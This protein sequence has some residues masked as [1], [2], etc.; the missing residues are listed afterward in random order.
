MGALDQFLEGLL[1]DGRVAFAGPPDHPPAADDLQRAGDRLGR[2]YP[3]HALDVAGPPIPFD[4]GAAT[5]A[6]VWLHWACWFA[7]DRSA[8][9]EL[10]GQ[11][12]GLPPAPG[13]A[14]EHLSAD[15]V[16]RFLP[17]V[18]RRAGSNTWDPLV[19]A[20]DAAGRHWPLSGVLVGGGEGPVE[21]GDLGGHPGLWL[22]YAERFARAP[23][24]GWEPPAGPIA[25]RLA[26]VRQVAG[27]GA[28]HGG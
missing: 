27:Q 2:A 21:V 13:T 25:D 5:R 26:W 28:Q 4:A 11:S 14:A 17:Q 20:I 15:L 1:G 16:L 10:V 9:A 22:L 7:V 6:A 23:R 8:P 12:L 18:R 24:S 19:K 3:D